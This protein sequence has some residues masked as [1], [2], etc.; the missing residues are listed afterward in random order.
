MLFLLNII[1]LT[2]LYELLKFINLTKVLK[3][4]FYFSKKIIKIILSNKISDRWKEKILLRYSFDLIKSSLIIFI[5]LLIILTMIYLGNYFN[6]RFILFLFS[7]KG[8]ISASIYIFF[9]VKIRNFL[10]EI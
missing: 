1:F 8:I 5:T 6:N 2:T 9:Y 4:L 10:N 3:N 7:L